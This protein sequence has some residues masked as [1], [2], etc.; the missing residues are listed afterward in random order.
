MGC[1]RKLRADGSAEDVAK[2]AE[3]RAG[4]KLM[5]AQP[6]VCVKL[7]MLGYS[8]PGWTV[9][10]D[11]EA[12]LQSLVLETISLFGAKR[13]MFASNF[14]VNAANSDSDGKC[15]V[16]YEIPALFDKF[17]SWTSQLTQADREELFAGSATRFYK[18]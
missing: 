15:D 5:A 11:K 17:A 18:L 4:M 9:D 3:W 6:Q 2:L 1:L 7:S 14:H 12:L 10:A 13:C 16:G 8:V